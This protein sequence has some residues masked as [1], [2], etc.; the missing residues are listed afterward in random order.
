MGTTILVIAC[1]MAYTKVISL[2]H[3]ILV[4]SNQ[5]PVDE[6]QMKW[7]AANLKWCQWLCT[8]AVIYTCLTVL[9]LNSLLYQ[10]DAL[11]FRHRLHISHYRCIISARELPLCNSHHR[12]S[13]ELHWNVL[14]FIFYF[15][16][17]PIHS[18][19]KK[20]EIVVFFVFL[21]RMINTWHCNVW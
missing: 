1:I 10:R 13:L 19:R 3:V 18:S 2:L 20:K 14:D 5:L 7:R 8:I 15:F 12:H 21:S 6:Y 9:S 4:G 11:D 17:K 16:T